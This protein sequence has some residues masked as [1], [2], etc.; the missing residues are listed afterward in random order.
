M[1]HQSRDSVGARAA[2]LGR[3]GR[4]RSAGAG[5][6]ARR[7]EGGGRLPQRSAPGA[8][9]LA[10]SHAARARTR[11]RRHRARGRRRRH[12]R[13]RP[14][15]HVVFCWAPA[16]GVCPSCA[17]RA[18]GPVRSARQDHVSQSAAVRRDTRCTRAA[19]TSRQFLEHGLLRRITR[20]SPRKPRSS[21]MR[22]VPFDALATLGCAVVTGVGAVLT[23]ARVP[24]GARVAVIGAGGVGLNVVQ[25]A[26]DRRRASGSSPSI[27]AG[28]ARSCADVR[29]DRRRSRPPASSVRRGDPRLTG[30]RGADFVFDTV[31][32]PA[33]L[34]RRAR[35]RRAR[36]ARWC[37]RACRASTQSARRRCSRSSC[38]RSG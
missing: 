35:A 36:A 18:R 9:R 24:A 38:R 32:T 30:G 8:R 3:R 23:A 25:G 21:S 28:A 4:A 11:R 10:D 14:G 19:R 7:G 26:V 1:R 34:D 5:R 12:A 31:G 17:R 33:T 2:A 13:V 16:C 20:S 22:D 29:R 27:A 15:D 6:S 37:S